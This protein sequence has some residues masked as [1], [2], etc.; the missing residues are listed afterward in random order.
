MT[1]VAEGGAY[2]DGFDLLEPLVH[3]AAAATV[4]IHAPAPGYALGGILE[5]GTDGD[6]APRPWGSGFFIAPNWVLTCAHVVLNSETRQEATAVGQSAREVAVSFSGGTVA[7]VVEWAEPLSRAGTGIWPAPDLALIRL[8]EP[9]EHPCVWVS[10]RSAK[11]VSGKEVAYFGCTEVEGEIQDFYGRCTIRGGLGQDGILRLGNEDEMPEGVSGGP[12]VDLSRGEVLG[13]VKGRRRGL[14]GGLA[15]SLVQLRRIPAPAAQVRTETDDLYQRVIHAHDRHHADRQH[16]VRSLSGT[17]TEAQSVIRATAGRALTP[18]QRTELLGLLAELPP[19]T[20]TRALEALV[21]LVHRGHSPMAP[22]APRSWREGMGLLYDL[23]SGA[24]ELEAVLRYAV[25][26]A[27]AERPY[28]ALSGTERGIWRWVEATAAAAAVPRHV[29]RA[30]ADER[31]SRLRSRA[32]TSFT[33]LRASTSGSSARDVS[34]LLELVPRG[35][36]P[37]RYDWRICLVHSSGGLEPLAEDFAGTALDELPQRLSGSL[38]EAFR[39]LDEPGRPAVLQVALPLP[40]LGLPV[41]DWPAADGRHPVGALRPVVVRRSDRSAKESAHHL[42]NR[43]RRWQSVHSG[44]LLPFTVLD[45]E[46]SRSQPLPDIGALRKL[47]ARTLPALCRSAN[48]HHTARQDI[49]AAGY[50]VALWRREPGGRDWICADFHR[51]LQWTVRT[52]G[53]ADHLPDIVWRLRADT[54]AGVPE[55]YWS[56]GI[57]LLYDDPT[58]PLPDTDEPLETP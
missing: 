12:V 32:V 24:G 29:R 38:T 8:L 23:R 25:L 36:E 19:P 11:A 56:K 40:L 53:R 15:V 7:G 4:R 30:L 41:H 21:A 13:V 3:L 1:T 51:G 31:E 35:W 52:A 39:R 57:A 5:D 48:R 47:H 28:P 27:T 17:W 10:E 44:P 33:A 16:D 20:S 46:D 37:D 58:R 14:D 45:C 55:A 49:V 2:D 9:V 34:V 43:E 42:A 6:A 26:A 50:G 22:L 54:S 18:G